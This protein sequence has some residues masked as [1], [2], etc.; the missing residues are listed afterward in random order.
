MK[1]VK[2]LLIA[3]GITFVWGYAFLA[4]LFA[5]NY[6]KLD[7]TCHY[8][9]EHFTNPAERYITFLPISVDSCG[10]SNATSMSESLVGLLIL[11]LPAIIYVA[12]LIRRHRKI[13]EH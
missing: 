6:K 10:N 9:L 13:S 3:V 8:T 1:A 5:I 12:I 4:A 11:L 2:R 7:V